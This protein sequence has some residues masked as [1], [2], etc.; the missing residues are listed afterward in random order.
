MVVYQ[1]QLPHTQIPSPESGKVFVKCPFCGEETLC[2]TRYLAVNGKKCKKCKALHSK[3]GLTF[4]E[5]V[6]E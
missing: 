5:R 4:N 1:E 3:W 6:R 2:Y